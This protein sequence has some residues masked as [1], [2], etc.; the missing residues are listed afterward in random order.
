MG[1]LDFTNYIFKRLEQ[2]NL[3]E[4]DYLNEWSVFPPDM[5][6]RI[7]KYKKEYIEKR[8]ESKN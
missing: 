7:N 3:I 1:D 4:G 8:K 5:K 6:K 2:F